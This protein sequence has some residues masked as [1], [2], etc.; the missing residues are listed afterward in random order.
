MRAE[1]EQRRGI[2]QWFSVRAAQKI[3]PHAWGLKADLSFLG[4]EGHGLRVVVLNHQALQFRQSPPVRL[5]RYRSS[6]HVYRAE[7]LALPR[8]L[9][10]FEVDPR[11][12][13][14]TALEHRQRSGL[15]QFIRG[16]VSCLAPNSTHPMEMGCALS[17]ESGASDLGGSG[18]QID[19]DVAN[20]TWTRRILDIGDGLGRGK[21]VGSPGK[22]VQRSN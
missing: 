15:L 7:Q 14:G 22:A 6:G 9:V 11:S 3:N 20:C 19:A 18:G 12:P 17:P 8:T 13:E 2:L 16:A 10:D 4:N 5:L 1:D 21:W